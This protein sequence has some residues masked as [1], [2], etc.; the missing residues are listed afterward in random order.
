MIESFTGKP[1]DQTYAR[2]RL[3]E[4]PLDEATQI[5]GDG[6]IHLCPAK[7][8]GVIMSSEVPMTTQECPY[9]GRFSIRHRRGWLR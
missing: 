8:Y 3:R 7:R 5:K 9:T 2:I 1:V 6:K 4:K